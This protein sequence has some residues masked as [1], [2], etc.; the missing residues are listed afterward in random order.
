VPVWH[1]ARHELPFLFA[2]GA[3]ASA[4]AAAT[5]FLPPA[6]ATAAR[7]LAIVGAVAGEV[8]MTA[9]ERRLGFVGEPYRNGPAAVLKQVSAVAALGGAALLALRGRRSRAAAVAGGALVLG[10]ELATRFSVFKA[11]FASAADPAYTVRP[12]RERLRAQADPVAGDD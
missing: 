5:L 6:E 9:M 7:R 10:G 1:E 3:G 2:S 8:V 4:G 12:Q 11:G